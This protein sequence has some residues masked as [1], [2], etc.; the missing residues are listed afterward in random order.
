MPVTQYALIVTAVDSVPSTEL[1]VQRNVL[2]NR[3]ADQVSSTWSALGRVGALNAQ[4]PNGSSRGHEAEP[5]GDA[6]C[7]ES[8]Q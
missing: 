2:V 7:A 1:H 8:A 4:R 5:E 6:D 3:F